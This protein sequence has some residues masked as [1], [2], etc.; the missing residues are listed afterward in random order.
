MARGGIPTVL[1][2]GEFIRAMAEGG[3]ASPDATVALRAH[4][5]VDAV[6][7]S[8]AAGGVPTRV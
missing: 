3:P 5:L 7:R 2:E 8:A 4:E 6:Y 1:P